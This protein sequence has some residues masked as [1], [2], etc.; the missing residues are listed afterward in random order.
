MSLKFSGFLHIDNAHFS[1]IGVC[2]L[3][4]FFFCYGKR[5]IFFPLRLLSFCKGFVLVQVLMAALYRNTL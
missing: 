4:F 3:F 2:C 1:N 5:V